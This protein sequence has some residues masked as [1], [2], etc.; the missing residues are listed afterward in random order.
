MQFPAIRPEM[1]QKIDLA[2]EHPFSLSFVLSEKIKVVRFNIYWIRRLR[3]ADQ[4]SLF[5]SV[6][7]QSRIV[8][9]VVVYLQK[10]L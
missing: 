9:F 1:L 7:Y 5:D 8:S 3:Q 10:I 6:T 2:M 4:L